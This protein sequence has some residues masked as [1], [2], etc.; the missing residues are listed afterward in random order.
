M[1]RSSSSSSSSSKRMGT[2]TQ[3]EVR[4]LFVRVVGGEYQGSGGR[5]RA[6]TRACTRT[7]TIRVE[8]LGADS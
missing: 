3:K 6:R 1:Y 2:S 8:G 7:R 5:P 4:P